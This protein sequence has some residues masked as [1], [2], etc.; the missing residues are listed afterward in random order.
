VVLDYPRVFARNEVL[1][2][3]TMFWWGY[4]FTITLHL[5]G[6]YHEA[7]LSGIR[8]RVHLLTAREFYVGTSHE[9]WRHELSGDNYTCVKGMDEET[10]RELLDRPRPFLK[11]ASGCDLTEWNKAPDLLNDLFRVIVEVCG[12]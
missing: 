7:M 6:Q 8:D 10:A 9:E 2:I 5:K 11:I 1:A 4:Y 12:F 3:R